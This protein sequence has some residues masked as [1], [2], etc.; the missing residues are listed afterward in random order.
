[1]FDRGV[2]VRQQNR[3]DL[4]VL[5]AIDGF[6][7]KAGSAQLKLLTALAEADDR[8]LWRR[9]GCRDMASWVSGRLGISNWSA[10]RWI[11]AAHA[12]PSLPLISAALADGTLCLDKVLDLCRFATED[13]E[14]RLISW[15]QRVSAATVR[16]RADKA[17]RTDKDAVVAAEQARFVRW[18]WLDDGY[19][20][21]LEGHFPAAQGAVIASALERAAELIPQLPPE[22]AGL[23]DEPQVAELKEQ[24]LADALWALCSKQIAGDQEPDRAAVV[25]HTEISSVL[26]Q[27]QEAE[28]EQGPVLHQDVCRRLSCDSRLRFVLTDK[29]GN[30]LGIGRS[31]RDV[32]RWLR[33]QLW[34]R[35]RGCTFPGCGGRAFVQAHHI[36]AWEEGGPTDYDNLVLVCL[37]HH[38][39]VHE[40]SWSVAL[41]GD[42]AEWFRADG[43]RYDPGPDPP[44]G[45]VPVAA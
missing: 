41:N 29:G 40:F 7:A 23:G 32:P 24:K 19:R 18:W 44:S 17:T 45:R 5:G 9:D 27:G 25:V 15:A 3:R 31:S 33:R 4:E 11:V 21:G 26:G 6:H 30:A 43:S 2:N 38:K 10:R 14:Q 1:L 22:V 28:L 35:D 8:K 37:F 39:L 34:Y 16:T 36:W 20:M 12:L 13:T 42:R